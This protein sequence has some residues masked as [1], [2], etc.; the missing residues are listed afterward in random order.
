MFSDEANVGG[1]LG[2]TMILKVE[3]GLLDPSLR[4]TSIRYVLASEAS[5]GLIENEEP[6]R[7]TK[8]GNTNMVS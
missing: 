5:V 2:F 3:R 4:V 6:V 8:L 1:R 7:V